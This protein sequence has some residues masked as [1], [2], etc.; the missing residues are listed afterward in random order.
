MVLNKQDYPLPQGVLTSADA[1]A[2]VSP[3]MQ[4]ILSD[5][6]VLIIS[7]LELVEK[8]EDQRESTSLRLKM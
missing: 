2:S 1:F 4:G 3:A 7:F 6:N 8:F 5:R